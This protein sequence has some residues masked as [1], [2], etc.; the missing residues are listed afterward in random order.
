MVL[1]RFVGLLPPGGL[2]FTENFYVPLGGQHVSA[3]IRAIWAQQ[4]AD[5]RAERD[6]PPT[7]RQV[8]AEILRRDTPYSVCCIAAGVHQD[9]QQR[10]VSVSL[11]D[12]LK[13]FRVAASLLPASDKPPELKDELILQRLDALGIGAAP[14]TRG[15]K[16]DSTSLVC[17]S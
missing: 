11:V 3:A 8:R 10:V 13:N 7:L 6:I 14:I 1:A 2:P 12:V 9:Q 15:K 5:G 17:L 16:Q 4:L